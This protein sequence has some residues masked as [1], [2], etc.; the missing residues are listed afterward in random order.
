M[1]TA[2]A[3]QIHPIN[4]PGFYPEPLGL[5]KTLNFYHK[6]YFSYNLKTIYNYVNE[7]TINT[8]QILK[9][10]NQTNSTLNKQLGEQVSKKLI[11]IKHKIDKIINQNRYKRSLI[12]GLGNVIRFITGNLDQTDLYNINQNIDML[13]SNQNKLN[14]RLS[15]SVTLFSNI[16]DK[17]YSELDL[18]SKN[19]KHI[20]SIV[21][22]YKNRFYQFFFLLQHKELL[23]SFE[24]QI[25]ILSRTIS[26][27][28]QEIPNL[29]MITY[30]ELMQ[31]HSELLSDYDKNTLITYNTKHPF[32]ILQN[33]KLGIIAINDLLVMVLKVPILNPL[34]Y[35]ISQ[36]YP[37]PNNESIS[38]IPPAKFYLKNQLES[39]WTDT[40]QSTIGLHICNNLLTNPCELETLKRCT[41]AFVPESNV[42]KPI[43]NGILTSFSK[44]KEVIEQCQSIISRHIIQKSNIINS[45]CPV[46]ID[47]NMITT[48]NQTIDVS[49][50][51]NY[52]SSLPSPSFE[53]DLESPHLEEIHKLKEDLKPLREDTLLD[54]PIHDV[55]HLT[56]SI[57]LII[58]IIIFIVLICI[59][60]KRLFQLFCKRRL[61]ITVD[62]QQLDNLRPSL[63]EDVKN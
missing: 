24:N 32:E 38:L 50:P 9:Q 33:S 54:G 28:N 25:D 43:S 61:L 41:T 5:A 21:E 2:Q 4:N 57:V 62:A 48:H 45:L 11:N 22:M 51:F 12:D 20:I 37:L 13:S 31:I 6:I 7:L 30:K 10:C 56:S 58:I 27:T 19:Q 14:K 23:N 60:R 46:I 3:L 34:P 39:R 44:P 26:L 55:T 15:Q 8:M 35:N 47:N 63:D 59:F 53:V 40:C 36:I 52:L 17:F 16:T 18:L 42:Y 29:E 49:M 1:G